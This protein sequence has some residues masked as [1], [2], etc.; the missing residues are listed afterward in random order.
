MIEDNMLPGIPFWDR[1]AP[2]CDDQLPLIARAGRGLRGDGYVVRIKQDSDC[3]TYLE[4]LVYDPASKTY[5]SDWISENIN[6]GKMMYQYNLRPYTNPQTFTITFRVKRPNRPEWVWT[7]PAIPY[8]W[9]AD[10]DGK[11]DVDGIV[12]VGVASL[13]LKKTTE[14]K[15]NYPT[16]TYTDYKNGLMTWEKHDKLVYPDEWTREML[17]A[18]T[19]GDPYSVNINYGIGGDLDAP[20]VD[21]IAKLLGITVENVRK[22]I[23]ESPV[24]THT[25]PDDNLKSYIDNMVDHVAIASVNPE[26]LS[27]SK[28]THNHNGSDSDFAYGVDFTLDPVDLT[29]GDGIGID[30]SGGKATFTNKIVAGPGISIERESDGSLQITNTQVGG[31]W[32]ELTAGVDFDYSWHN[33][34][35]G[36]SPQRA[37]HH[38]IGPV[39]IIPPKIRA[40]ISYAADGKTIIGAEVKVSDPENEGAKEQCLCNKYNLIHTDSSGNLDQFSF[41]HS[42]TATG[43]S[44]SWMLSFSFK[45]DYA[46][47]NKL[48]VEN[49]MSAGTNI[50]NVKG[51]NDSI[52]GDCDWTNCGASWMVNCNCDMS[53]LGTNHNFT[54]YAVNISDGYN[55]QYTTPKYGY[56][57]LAIRPWAN[58]AW[59]ITLQ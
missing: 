11:A 18:P 14:S 28:V 36:G 10:N 25:I 59:R 3:E 44:L 9:D 1:P 26:L 56:S 24:P 5:T 42:S 32:V 6:G 53:V 43:N 15:W 49:C 45:G 46:P 50:W 34:W 51:T 39:E 4:G 37:A 29:E 55:T 23:A 52:A 47:L 8:I 30:I 20:N 33:G 13:F 48:T 22:I 31:D 7:T 57:C 41:S 2:C 27:V 19:P 40:I 16:V 38:D 54:I 35:Y 12:G 21:D 58:W 17:N